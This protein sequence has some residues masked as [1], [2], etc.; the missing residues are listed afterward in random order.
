M[1]K[2][3]GSIYEERDYTKFRRLGSN[4]DVLSNR[5]NKLI[6]SISEKY[7]L[8]P[9]V[10]NEFYEVIDGQGRFEAC[11]AL[12]KPIH[13]IIAKGA[14]IDDCR[15]MN[16]YNTKWGLMDFIDSFSKGLNINYMIMKNVCAETGLGA[17][18]VLRLAN[19]GYGR[20]DSP[21]SMSIVESGR[22][23][24][25]QED[26][27][28]VIRTVKYAKEIVDALQFDLRTN[29]AFLV[30]VKVASETDGYDHDRMLKNCQACRTTYNQMS[31]LES[32]LKELERIYNYRAKIGK[33]YFS[34]YMR[35]KGS[36][37]RDYNK[38]KMQTYDTTD[39]SSLF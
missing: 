12:G 35:N 4:R 26:A 23:I 36:N 29:D 11:R 3:I 9:I 2:V 30:A 22:L 8:N 17:Y 38:M 15:R 33:L 34:D 1:A 19:H 5:L 7:I 14:T 28:K 31:N 20:A 39:R 32:E 13:Y 21:T 10:V 37:I 25:T 16:K 24:F 27:E 18:K 6:A